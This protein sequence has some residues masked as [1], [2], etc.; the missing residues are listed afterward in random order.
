VAIALAFSALYELFEWATALLIGEAADSFLGSQGDPWDTQND[1][2]LALVGAVLAQL[3][4]GRMQERQ[5]AEIA[6]TR[7][8]SDD[9]A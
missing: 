4:L 3:L 1:M 6:A 7:R 9:G 5:V 8:R 2:F